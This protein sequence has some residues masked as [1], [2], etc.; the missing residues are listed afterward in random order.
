MPNEQVLEDR[1]VLELRYRM[2]ISQ[3]YNFFTGLEEGK[4][5]GTK[6]RDCGRMFFPPQTDCPV[7]MKKNMEWVDLDGEST[8]ET[9]SIVEVTPTSFTSEGSYVVAVGLLREGVRVLSWLNVTDRGSIK[10]GMK[11][12]LKAVK[13]KEGYFSYEFF[14]Y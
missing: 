8:L 11:M 7:C 2:P 6:C 13:K 10:I 5:R 1:R 14:S 12:R 9:F 3:I 4:V